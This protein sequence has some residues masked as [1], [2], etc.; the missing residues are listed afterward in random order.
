LVPLILTP[1]LH[2]AVGVPPFAALWESA[3]DVLRQTKVLVIVGYSFPATDFHV[4]RLLREAFA[5]RAPERLCIVNPDTSVVS[6][7]RDLS[8]FTGTALVSRDVEAYLAHS[9]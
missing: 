1:T 6:I 9:W 3:R 4:R 7:S 8:H 2:K 5:D